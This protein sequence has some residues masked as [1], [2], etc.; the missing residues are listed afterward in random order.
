MV[1]KTFSKVAKDIY[2][3]ILT[4]IIEEGIEAGSFDTEYSA[5]TI[6]LLLE[7]MRYLAEFTTTPQSNKLERMIQA[8]NNIFRKSLGSKDEI[9]IIPF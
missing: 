4:A 9:L 2:L 5:E 7:I 3:P 8:T 6:E 1:L